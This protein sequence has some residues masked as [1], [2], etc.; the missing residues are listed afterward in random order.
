MPVY[1]AAS[2]PGEAAAYAAAQAA[3]GQIGRPISAS[4]MYDRLEAAYY[5]NQT[6]DDITQY[7]ARAV[8]APNPK[9]V[10]AL[11][12]PAFRVVEFYPGHLWPGETLETAF[13]F[14]SKNARI[15]A[16]ARKVWEWSN[17]GARR[18]TYARRYAMLGN[19]FVKVAQT[20]DKSRVFFRYLDPRWVTR[21]LFD[22]QDRGYLIYIRLD[23]PQTRINARGEEEDFWITEI[24]DKAADRFQR[25]QH[26]S[27]A[28]AK[29]ET[30]GT[31]THNDAITRLFGIEFIPIVHCPFRDDAS[32][33][34]L[35]AYQL[36]LEKIDEA[37]RMA[38]ELH[39]KLF[40]HNQPTN[41]VS[42]NAVD[43]TGKP[44]PA[45]RIPGLEG[46]MRQPAMPGITYGTNGAQNVPGPTSEINIV[47][48][49]DEQ[50]IYLDGNATVDS[51]IPQ[52]A[53][54]DA[55]AILVNYMGELSED[56]PEM[57]YA[58]I[59]SL[60]G[61][62]SGEALRVRLMA[63]IDRVFEARANILPALVRLNQ[64]AITLGQNGGL[65]TDVG[66]F[67]KGELDHQL[68]LLPVIPQSAMEK[69]DV[70]GKT[71]ANALVK[72]QAGWPRRTIWIEAGYTPAE[73]D[74]M[75]T[76]RDDQNAQ[77]VELAQR[78]FDRGDNVDGLGGNA[79][80]GNADGGSSNG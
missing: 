4:G 13:T 23:I 32:G 24:W 17:F 56:L 3:I 72:D 52:I 22:E 74:Q 50:W 1:G 26:E 60:P 64:I 34:G 43:K 61:D 31:P 12:N 79:G 66:S 36:Q 45:P 55:L 80:D 48:V 68:A 51:L 21:H 9:R 35:G 65:F 70:E 58:Q 44:L 6:F 46:Y 78:A 19:L 18:Q 11:M 28:D 37:N 77:S 25:W 20:A 10:R 41:V 16:A 54:A 14:T 33:L 76:A 42:A 53:W 59:R 27:G 40:R 47:D 69:L 5:N 71:A 67:E 73:A 29:P 2:S 57:I 15:E 38:T 62:A 7:I 75:I 63:A 39:G 8:G 30:M 49:G